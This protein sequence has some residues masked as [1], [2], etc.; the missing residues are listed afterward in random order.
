M[1]QCLMWSEGKLVSSLSASLKKCNL[2]LIDGTGIP[3]RNRLGRGTCRSV[4]I[5]PSWASAREMRDGGLRLELV[6]GES[7]ALVILVSYNV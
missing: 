1:S 3:A 7:K 5:G 2:V 6:A 4:S